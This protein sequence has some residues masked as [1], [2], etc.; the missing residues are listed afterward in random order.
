MIAVIR[1]VG[2]QGVNVCRTQREEVIER[3]TVVGFSGR[4]READG[5]AFG[6]AAGVDF[7]REAATRAAKSFGALNPPFIPA[8]F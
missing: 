6:I 7:A 1:F 5:P 8:A 2:Q 4:E 3:L